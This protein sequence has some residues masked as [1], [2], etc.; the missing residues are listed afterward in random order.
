MPSRCTHCT[1]P[2]F[3][4]EWQDAGHDQGGVVLIRRTPGNHLEHDELRVGGLST[5]HPHPLARAHRRGLAA[6]ADADGDDEAGR[7]GEPMRNDAALQAAL[8]VDGEQRD[9]ATGHHPERVRGSWLW[10]LWLLWLLSLIHISEPTRQAEISY[11]V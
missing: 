11:A 9:L 8:E 7:T 10:L 4:G 2:A 1:A 6:G 3:A 5:G